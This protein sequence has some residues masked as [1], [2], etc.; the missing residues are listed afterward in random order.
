MSERLPDKTAL[1]QRFSV[2]F[3]ENITRA[4]ADDLLKWLEAS[5]FFRAPASTRFHGSYEG[6]L[7]EHSLNVYDCLVKLVDT[8][9]PEDTF[10]GETITLVSLLHDI[11]KTNF[12]KPDTRNRKNP[13]TNRWEVV[14]YYSIEDSFPIGHS[15]KSVIMIQNFMRLTRDEILAIRA[16]M[17]GFDSAVKGGDSG[18]ANIMSQCRLAA[19]LH[20]ADLAATH[21]IET[22]K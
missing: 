14:P 15:E 13:E 5:D 4:G 11:C 9:G 3:R 7:V 10:S 2:L 20:M 19:L 18:V 8:F 17:G 1:H 21:L 16:H 22:I 6:G 12:Y